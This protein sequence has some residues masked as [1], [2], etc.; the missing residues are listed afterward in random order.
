M[1]QANAT[2]HEFLTP[3]ECARRYGVGAR[4]I[5]SAIKRG[6]LPASTFGS[7]WFRIRPADI[8][9]WFDRTRFEPDPD[10]VIERVA[11]QMR[12]EDALT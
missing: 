5:R 6:D 9:A 2:A 8:E 11:E 3:N 10:P 1:A 12:R 4:R 7:S